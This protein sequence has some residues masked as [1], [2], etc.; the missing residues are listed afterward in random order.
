[1]L[2]VSRNGVYLPDTL[3]QFILN[4]ALMGVNMLM[5]YTEDTYEVPGQHFRGTCADVTPK[6]NCRIWI[7]TPMPWS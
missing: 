3:K 4:S 2:D 1:M 5:L 6:K 7:N